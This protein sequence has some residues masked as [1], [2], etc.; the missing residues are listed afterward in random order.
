MSTL[1]STQITNSEPT[2]E[3]VQ[4]A[5]TEVSDSNV[6]TTTEDI[7]NSTEM[8][9][10]ADLEPTQADKDAV[11]PDDD[12]IINI[13]IAPI[14]KKRFSVNGDLDCM[15]ELNI[16]DVN[17]VQRLNKSLKKLN[18]LQQEAVNT[19]S[20]MGDVDPSSDEGMEILSE[21]LEKIDND[22]RELVDY[23]FNA[24]VSKVCARDG[25]MYDMFKGAFRYEHIIESLMK[26]YESN[27][28]VEYQQMRSNLSKH[29]SKYTKS[30][31]R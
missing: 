17:I 15:L 23:I 22:M 28:K 18:E 3:A 21:S 14:K 11:T 5:A 29:T 4:A 2:V 19:T 31:K 13:D 10:E 9:T 8:T 20:K 12:G 25:S 26:L 7:E 1:L 30:R 6:T 27:I 16:A 24:E